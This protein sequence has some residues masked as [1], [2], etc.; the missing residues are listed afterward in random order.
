MGS[1]RVGGGS[2]TLGRGLVTLGGAV[3]AAVSGLLLAV[4]VGRTLGTAGAGVFFSIVAFVTI[5]TTVLKLG[6]DTAQLWRIPPLLS[7]GRTDRLWPTVR[8]AVIPTATLSAAAALTV[9]LA[10]EPLASLLVE[11]TGRFQ[12]AEQLRWSALVVACLAPMTVLIATTRA[13]GH[14]GPF[15][16]IHNVGLP[17][18]RLA[19]VGAAL[20]AGTGGTG[21]MAAW[22]IPV[23]VAMLVAAVMVRRQVGALVPA[24]QPS[25]PPAPQAPRQPPAPPRHADR[26]FWSFA[27][28]RGVTASLEVSLIA[29][30]TLLVGVMIG[31]AAAGVFG[32]LSR[33]VTTG[34]MAEQAV[35]ILVAPRFSALL[36]QDDLEGASQLYQRTTPWIVA[37]SW[38][39]FL[40]I[41]S[42]APALL[43]IFGPGFDAGAR[44][45]TV[46]ALAM[47][48]SQVAGNVQTV[49]LMSGHSGLQLAN[50][51]VAIVVL[52]GLNLWLI[53][54]FGLVGA[55][56]AWSLAILTDTLLAVVEVRLVVGIRLLPS[57]LTPLAVLAVAAFAVP[58]LVATRV[59]AAGVPGLV[60][61][62]V[63]GGLVYS[64]VLWRWRHRL[65]V[66]ALVGTSERSATHPAGP[67]PGRPD[68]G[69]GPG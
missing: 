19:I 29:A 64:P 30:N 10:A 62:V 38:P 54:R 24:G 49:L 13:L 3:I 17:I 58:T 16:G 44:A 45:L 52:V 68:P 32:A 20:L 1:G 39:V 12:T 41:A 26:D 36:N 18:G 57:G 43:T 51:L 22:S 8:T 50:K 23:V 65:E 67:G 4:L 27:V 28:P 61:A 14:I 31:P 63:V 69:A 35:R 56:V 9:V 46:L 33:F 53:P 21:A 7:E 42:G 37:V 60:G 6:T 25:G 48:L 40:V 55:A 47:C 5:L 15:V 34:T 66:G 2:V 11:D 59:L